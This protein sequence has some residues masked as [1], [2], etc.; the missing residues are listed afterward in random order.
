[1]GHAGEALLASNGKELCPLGEAIYL[2]S[3]ETSSAGDGS[4]RGTIVSVLSGCESE[5]ISFDSEPSPECPCVSLQACVEKGIGGYRCDSGQKA[6][7]SSGGTYTGR[8]V[9]GAIPSVRGESSNRQP[10]LW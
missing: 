3:Q 4:Q 8:G 2:L 9:K 5:G 1:M 6:E 10:T 7:A